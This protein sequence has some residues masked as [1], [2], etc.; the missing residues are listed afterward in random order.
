MTAFIWDLDGTLIDSYG[1][2]MKALE[3]T[4]QAFKLDFDEKTVYDFIKTY[5]TNQLLKQQTVDFD[6]LHAKFSAE[7][8]KLNEE[9][10]LLPGAY[11]VLQWAQA[12]GF[13]QFIYTHKGKNTYALL[14]QLN[15]SSF[16]TE[17]LTSNNGFKRKPDPEGVNYLLSKYNLDKSSTYYIGDRA[18]D[19][20]VARNSGIQ[21]INFLPAENSLKMDHLTDIM[22]NLQISK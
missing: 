22:E 17:I 7:S 12:Q 15:L 5:S 16:F 9:I 14:E 4:F 19:I 6:S 2:F 21:S 20:E 13:Q 3:K 10:Q 11:Q 18:L 1:V 8:A